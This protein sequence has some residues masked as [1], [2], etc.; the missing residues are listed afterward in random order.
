M[1]NDFFKYILLRGTSQTDTAELE[2]ETLPYAFKSNGGRLRNY[3]IY[4]AEGGVG[5]IDAESGKYIIPVIVY[6]QTEN[7]VSEIIAGKYY[8]GSSEVTNANM[9]TSDFI[10][11]EPNTKYTSAH[12]DNSGNYTGALVFC[13]WTSDKVFIE[14]TTNAETITTESNAK[15]ITVRNFASNPT[16]T[17]GTNF[18]LVKGDTRPTY[19]SQTYF[20]P[21][22]Y[23]ISLDEPLRKIG[24]A[25]D[26]VDFKQQKLYQK[27]YCKIL[28]GNETW[29]RESEKVVFRTALKRKELY[30]NYT[31]TEYT[32]QN[33]Y[34]DLLLNDKSFYIGPTAIIIHDESYAAETNEQSVAL[35]VA[36]LKTKYLSNQPVKIYYSDA[37]TEKTVLLP[38]IPTIDGKNI[39]SVETETQP[40]KIYLQGKISEAE[41]VSARSLQT[42]MQSL[43]PL[44]LDDEDLELDVMPTDNDLQI[45]VKPIEKPVLNLNDVS[46]IEN[47]EIERGVESAE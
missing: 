17:K 20:L 14:Q 27:I 45:D 18:C 19:V 25:F 5:D 16:S 30:Q 12:F 46:E 3:R 29:I 33:S 41:I 2:S 15:Y 31:S 35:F 21:K 4:G 34:N 43:Q 26:Y 6:G 36:A 10:E 47:A 11:I 37:A 40:S 28:T 13:T 39:I 24:N 9:A 23:S 44:S 38:A 8:N 42:N 1:R 7:L 22:T 32:A